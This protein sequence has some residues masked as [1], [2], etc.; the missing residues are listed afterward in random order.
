MLLIPLGLTVIIEEIVALIW[1]L[2]T[3]KELLTVLWV[4]AVT[5]SLVTLIRYFSN[6]WIHFEGSGVITIIVLELAVLIAEWRLFKKFIPRLSYPFIFSL[7]MNAA[8]YGAGLMLPVIY[9]ALN[10][11]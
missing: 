11:G 8:S 9:R 3:G 1:G 7:I 4:N 10:A 2:R 6:Q 5:N